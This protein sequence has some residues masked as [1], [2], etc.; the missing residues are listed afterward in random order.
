[1][2]W[3]IWS[4]LVGNTMFNGTDPRTQERLEKPPAGFNRDPEGLYRKKLYMVENRLFFGVVIGDERGG[5]WNLGKK[6]KKKKKWYL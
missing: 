1:M 5:N 2:P 4:G 6:K 3:I